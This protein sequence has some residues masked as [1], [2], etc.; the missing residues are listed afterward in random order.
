MSADFLINIIIWLIIAGF[1]L[2]A[3]R[4]LIALVPMDAWLKQ[5]VDV[6]LYIVVGA[7][8]VFKIVIPLLSA[9]AHITVSVH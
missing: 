7:I 3:A 6:L 4:M 9:I 8:I 1:I 5:V 2:W